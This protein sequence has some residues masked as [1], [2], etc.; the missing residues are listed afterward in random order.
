M[1]TLPDYFLK[2]ARLRFREWT[3]ED[4]PLASALW[5]DANVTRLI[6][7]PFSGE[8]VR[9]RLVREMENLRAHGVQY[10]PV[11]VQDSREFAGCCGLRPCKQEA[12]VFELGFHFLTKHWG[13]SYA[14]ES[15]RAVI[16]YAFGSL[17]APG[18][19]RRVLEKL[20]F[21]F[22]HEELYPPTG[23][24]H[25]CYFLTARERRGESSPSG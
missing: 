22:T 15:S 7:G 11:F 21:Q 2:S 20:G 24:M 23:R 16:E 25:R 6:G 1:E 3:A 14:V 18:A 13:R 8:Q 10:W 9:E 4:L 5:G 19:S 17:R 12:G